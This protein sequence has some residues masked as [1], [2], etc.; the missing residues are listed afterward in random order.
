MAKC[1]GGSLAWGRWA[2]GP[3]HRPWGPWVSEQGSH[4]LTLPPDR[5]RG[6]IELLRAAG[7][8]LSPQELEDAGTELCR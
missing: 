8:C 2:P 5:H 3:K 6:V 7:A 1:R 4:Q